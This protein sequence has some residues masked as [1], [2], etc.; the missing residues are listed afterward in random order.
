MHL[1]L[2]QNA[3]IYSKISYIRSYM[4]RSR[5]TEACRSECR[6]VWCKLWHFVL[7]RGAFVGKQEF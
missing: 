6:I 2:I 3:K 5:W 1:L 4:L 7:I